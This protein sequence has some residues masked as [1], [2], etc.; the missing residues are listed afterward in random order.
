MQHNI[1]CV[2]DVH[3]T[4]AIFEVCER[5]WCAYSMNASRMANAILYTYGFVWMARRSLFSLCAVPLFRTIR[6]LLV[7]MLEQRCGKRVMKYRPHSIII[8][9]V[10]NF[11]MCLSCCCCCCCFS[12]PLFAVILSSL[13][14]TRYASTYIQTNKYTY[15]HTRSVL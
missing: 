1:L 13:N 12:V 10:L 6:L 8:I 7:L 14:E 4:A 3:Q 5:Y 9:C 2:C 15:S 11:G